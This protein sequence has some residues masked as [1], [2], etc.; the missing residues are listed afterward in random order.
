MDI[1]FISAFFLK[2]TKRTTRLSLANGGRIVV[3][4]D[5]ITRYSKAT[6]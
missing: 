5:I 2:Y 1:P 4:F 3:T 6:S